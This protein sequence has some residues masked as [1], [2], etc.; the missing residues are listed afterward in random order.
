VPDL[1]ADA[2]LPGDAEHLVERG[3]DR[4]R[5]GAL[6]R[7]VGAAVLRG[8]LRHR[9]QLVRRVV[10]VGH[11]L[12]RRRHA[13]RAVAHGLVDDFLHPRELLRRG[14]AVLLADD[15][16]AHAAG[17]D[18]GAEVDRGAAPL[19]RLEVAAE[20]AKVRGES[21]ALVDV[22]RLGEHRVVERRDRAAL[23]GDLRRD[24]L[25][26]LRR[27]ALVDENVVLG[28]AEQ[29]DEARADVEAARVDRPLR[30]RP[31]SG[32]MAA[33]FPP[34]TP[35]SAANHGAPVPST[36]RPPVIRRSN[37]S[38][39]GESARRHRTSGSPRS[40]FFMRGLYCMAIGD[41]GPRPRAVSRVP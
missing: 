28:L 14:A 41:V 25:R 9:D 39:E 18:E 7:E 24:A 40:S 17:A 30:G 15:E 23:A 20:R 6:V 29:V 33:I 4:V 10:H 36:T 31:A 21:V 38:S 22:G 34:R 26:D 5:L 2:R 8:D 11:V 19:K 32:P 16:V 37:G 3:V 27:G 1:A 13:E 35:T 12:E